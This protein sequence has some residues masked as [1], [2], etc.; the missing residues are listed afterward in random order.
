M[1]RVDLRSVALC[2]WVAAFAHVLVL[3]QGV[4]SWTLG[5]VALVASCLAGAL[6]AIW[7]A[8][9]LLFAPGDAN[10]ALDVLLGRTH[11]GSPSSTSQREAR[12]LDASPEASSARGRRLT[13]PP[14]SAATGKF[15]A[16]DDD[17]EALARETDSAVA[18]RRTSDASPSPS[19]DVS[20]VYAASSLFSQ[21][22]SPTPSRKTSRET[23][24]A[25]SE[26]AP[27]P[28]PRRNSVGRSETFPGPNRPIGWMDD[29]G[30][31]RGS[32]SF[33]G[34]P[35]L[36]QN[37]LVRRSRGQSMDVRRS[38]FSL[39]ARQSV[40][41]RRL[42]LDTIRAWNVFESDDSSEDD[43]KGTEEGWQDAITGIRG[44]AQAL[45]DANN[46][47]A[48]VSLNADLTV[49]LSNLMLKTLKLFDYSTGDSKGGDG[50]EDAAVL[51]LEDPHA[52]V[53]RV[54]TLS[55][56]L[57]DTGSPLVLFNRFKPGELSFVPRDTFECCLFALL[58]R[59]G[60]RVLDG[61]CV[62]TTEKI[63]A[64]EIAKGDSGDSGGG[65]LRGRPSLDSVASAR[66][67]QGE[68]KGDGHA[69]RVM[70]EYRTATRLMSKQELNSTELR[71]W[72]RRLKRVGG[73]LKFEQ[74]NV[75]I[76]G[77]HTERIIMMVPTAGSNTFLEAEKQE[78]A[79][80]IGFPGVG[81]SDSPKIGS[82][83]LRLSRASSAKAGMSLR[84]GQAA[85]AAGGSQRS[86]LAVVPSPGGSSRGGLALSERSG[87]EG[88]L[89]GREASGLSGSTAEEL[90]REEE[91]DVFDLEDDEAGANPFGY[92]RLGHHLSG[93]T[94]EGSG[95]M[96]QKTDSGSSLD[97][98][99]NLFMLTAGQLDFKILYIE[100]ERVQAYFFINK[101]RRVFG[102]RCVVVHETDGI[103][104]LERLKSGEQYTVIV[105][106][107][108]MSR[109][110]GV[111]F[112][113][114]LF[115]TNLNTGNLV[116]EGLS[117]REL[118]M[119]VILTGADVDEISADLEQVRSSYGVLVY[120]KTSS[121][122]VVGDVI[123]PH[124]SFVE[125]RL[126]DVI[127][128]QTGHNGGGGWPGNSVGSNVGASA[129]SSSK[130]AVDF[131]AAA[132]IGGEFL[133]SRRS[134][135]ASER[136][137]DGSFSLASVGGDS[138]SVEHSPLGPGPGVRATDSW[139][140]TNSNSSL[141]AK[142]IEPPTGPG[143]G[144]G[145]RGRDSDA[146]GSA[147][148]PV[149]HG[150]HWEGAGS[151]YNLISRSNT[152]LGKTSAKPFP[153]TTNIRRAV[154]GIDND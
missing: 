108:F 111:S 127:R 1:V 110:D 28:F 96:S 98:M 55:E 21:H 6:P 11:A 42:S 48:T 85:A 142:A 86:G 5:S 51:Q 76:I 2:T 72:K 149:D 8:S 109:M 41:R 113:H 31:S 119:N 65:G 3:V 58:Y 125:S 40:N 17:A 117:E 13:S 50:A 93:L 25:N 75:G 114:T 90:M 19:E 141:G 52:V 33:H 16:D 30:S 61:D 62:M 27:G 54:C 154:A 37:S 95:S 53:K 47:V 4:E 103:A 122:D 15:S 91:M 71:F 102:D 153:D 137:A 148:D 60:T 128:A 34:D 104:A 29:G 118:R 20:P 94:E 57:F 43:D 106:D 12:S 84:E 139:R 35:R 74:V 83:S 7:G 107:V 44:M 24:E 38:D 100:D 46:S 32:G 89:V 120:N 23:G 79:V 45:C 22:V 70:V 115:S 82:Q 77:S 63:P 80:R 143:L 18:A 126:R 133:R 131:L 124:I 14:A 105:S 134:K 138:F 129:R 146:W 39:D 136:S 130:S 56:P 151:A 49:S 88:D 26:R 67:R 64:D 152:S 36:S 121:I 69:L 135:R 81:Y 99:D 132:G 147:P 116:P 150:D 59:A 66:E 140:S 123:K 92:R 145:G 73:S 112:F 9:V 78:T 101:C 97:F 68:R 144:P 10:A 87:H